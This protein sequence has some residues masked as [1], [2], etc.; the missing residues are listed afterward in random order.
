MRAAKQTHH[1]QQTL[2]G[3]CGAKTSAEGNDNYAGTNDYGHVSRMLN[4]CCNRDD[5][6]VKCP[7]INRHP[8]PNEGNRNSSKLRNAKHWQEIFRTNRGGA[9]LSAF[10][11]LLC[12]QSAW[13][14][15]TVQQFITVHYSLFQSKLNLPLQSLPLSSC[16]KLSTNKRSNLISGKNCWCFRLPWC[17]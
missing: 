15:I 10:Q 8:D 7:L 14:F 16:F 9:D 11:G 12:I 17:F 3:G 13:Q 2:A 6:K 1:T 4:Q 5:S